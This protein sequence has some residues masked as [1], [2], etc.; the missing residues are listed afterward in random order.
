[1]LKIG[2]CFPEIDYRRLEIEQ[3]NE[4]LEMLK[5]KELYS[6]DMYTEFL[7]KHNPTKPLLEILKKNNIKLTFHYNGEFTLNNKLDLKKIKNDLKTL[8]K[9]LDKNKHYYQTL[10][11]FHIPNYVDNKYKHI[12]NM[13][14][15]FQEI[16]KYG[17]KLRF[18]ILVETLSNYHPCGQKIG[19]DYSEIVL[20]L[21]AIKEKN[22]G[23]CWDLGHTR[24]NNIESREKLYVPVQLIPKIRFT[25]IHNFYQK[26][27]EYIDHIPLTNLKKQDA[28]ICF[29]LKNNYK[30]IYHLEFPVENLK[31]NIYVYLDNIEKLKKFILKYKEDL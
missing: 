5:E 8:R 28:E 26:N 30:G 11:V 15:V 7:I 22:F 13:I 21:N 9:I 17:L 24:L 23:V 2:L 1:M 29:L 19:N 16:T 18:D 6:F 10:I 31:E 12:K 25:H 14:K 20:F 27:G 3:F 4:Y